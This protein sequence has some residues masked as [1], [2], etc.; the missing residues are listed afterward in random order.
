MA[1]VENVEDYSEDLRVIFNGNGNGAGRGEGPPFGEVTAEHY[2]EDGGSER[3]AF[4]SDKEGG[5]V[6]VK[7]DVSVGVDFDN[8]RG[9]GGRREAGGRGHGGSCG[10]DGHWGAWGGGAGESLGELEKVLGANED[11]LGAFHDI[12]GLDEICDHSSSLTIPGFGVF[13]ASLSSFYDI[14]LC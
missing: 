7:E 10:G 1:V 14:G 8:W 6:G 12:T 4:G 9:S 13:L 3:E 2:G 5:G 11:D